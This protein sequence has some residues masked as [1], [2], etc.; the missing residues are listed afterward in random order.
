MEKIAIFFAQNHQN[1]FFHCPYLYK[2]ILSFFVTH[3]RI[4]MAL[5]FLLSI[6]W[7]SFEIAAREA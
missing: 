1:L 2:N 5:N 7:F 3:L 4:H 6:T